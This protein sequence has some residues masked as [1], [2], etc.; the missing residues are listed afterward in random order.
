[1]QSRQ[2]T[3]WAVITNIL[4]V[5]FFV[6]HFDLY[7]SPCLWCTVVFLQYLG[8]IIVTSFDVFRSDSVAATAL[9]TFELIDSCLNPFFLTH[10]FCLFIVIHLTVTSSSLRFVFNLVDVQ[11]C[12]KI[13]G[14]HER[15]SWKGVEFR[16]M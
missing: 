6:N 11:L 15:G 13:L 10:V 3:T 9:Y 8:L 5:S 2:S 1:M 4:H 16:E 12:V 14:T 7:S